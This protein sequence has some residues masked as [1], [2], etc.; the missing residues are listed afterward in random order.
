MRK[1]QLSLMCKVVS[2]F[3][4]FCEYEIEHMGDTI[5]SMEKYKDARQD[6]IDF[7]LM[8]K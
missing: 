8:M 4:L 5:K 1:T 2:N 7:E 3:D 6:V